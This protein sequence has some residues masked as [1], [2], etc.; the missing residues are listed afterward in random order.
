MNTLTSKQ[1]QFYTSI[2][3]SWR[4]QLAGICAEP[5]IDE[6]VTFLQQRE[7]SG[8][9]IYPAKQN[10]FAALKVTPFD[11]VKVVI[12]GQDPY[13]GPGQAHGLSFS[14]PEGVSLPP[15]LKNIFKELARE[16]GTPVIRSGDLSDWASQG[17]LLLNAILTVERGQPAAHAGKGWE[18]FTDAIIQ[19]LLQRA[20]PVVFMLWGA[21]AQKKVAHIASGAHPH[22]LILKAAHPSPFSVTGF[23]GCGHFLQANRFLISQGATPITWHTISEK[24]R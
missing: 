20:Q 9:V 17:V 18:L 6:L 8:A 7:A 2:P 12:V 4:D 24:K 16:S 14:V 3:S 11:Q 10:I 15:S 23:L 19:A 21:Y 5:I 1:Q 13:H 22:H